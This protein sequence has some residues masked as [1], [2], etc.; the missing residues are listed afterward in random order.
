LNLSGS[1]V[2]SLQMNATAPDDVALLHKRR[3]RWRAFHWIDAEDEV[4]RLAEA[5]STRS[6]ESGS[7]LA[8]SGLAPILVREIFDIVTQLNQERVWLS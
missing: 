1:E 6:F 7:R 5:L 8:V 2:R 4:G 3:G